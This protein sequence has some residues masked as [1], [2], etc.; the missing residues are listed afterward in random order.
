MQNHLYRTLLIVGVVLASA[1]QVYPTVGWVLLDDEQR[2]ARTEKWNEEDLARLREDPGTLKKAGYRIKRWSEYDRGMVINLGL[3]LLGGLHMVLGFDMTPEALERELTESDV[4]D[5]ILRNVR[6]RVNE[7]EAKEPIIQKLGSN[8]IQIQLP[9]EKD[10]QRAKNLIMKTAFLTFHIVSGPDETIKILSALDAHFANGFVPFLDPPSGRGG[11]FEVRLEHFDLVNSLVQQALE[12]PGLIPPDTTIAFSPPPAPWQ[13]SGYLIYVM[14]KKEGMT[15]EDLKSAVARPDDQSPSS[16]LILFEFGA[17]GSR[18]FARLTEENV[19]RSMAIVVDGHVVSAPNISER[20]FGSGRITGSFSQEE[21]QDLA[22]ALNSGSMPVPVREDYTAIVGPTLG[23]DSVERGINSSVIGLVLVMVFMLLYYRVA[24]IVA[25]ISLA[26]NALLILGAFGY[27]DVTLTLPGI[28]G[29][30]L[31][32]GMA[33]D[34]NV[35]IFE[36]I[37][38]EQAT[39][40]SFAAC[41]E[42][43]FDSATSAII[44]ANVTT[45]IAAAVL[46]QFGT[47]PVQGFAIA[48]SIGVVSSVFSA[49]VITRALMDFIA[50]HKL[51]ERLGMA[52]LV[53]PGTKF[54]FLEKRRICAIVSVLAILA[55]AGIFA[56]RGADNFGVDFKNGT[57]AIVSL[58]SAVAV[59]AGSLRDALTDA[60]FDAPT[61][62]EYEETD[63]EHPN[64]F[65]IRVGETGQEEGASN[66]PVSTRIQ[67]AL[68]PLTDNPTSTD[69]DAEVTILRAETVGPAVG[70][71][72]QRDALNAIFFALIFIVLYLWF[73]FEWKFALGAV[74]ALTHDVLIVIGIIALAG[75]EITIPVIAAL[76]TIIGYSLN[77]TIVVF[78]RIREDIG[79]NKARGLS[80]MENL[81]MSINRTLSRTLLTSITTLFVVVVLFIFGGSAINDFAFALIAGVIVGTYSSVFVATPVVYAWENWRGSGLGGHGP[82]SPSDEG[83]GRTGGTRRRRR[84][85]TSTA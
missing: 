70:E 82:A 84:Q 51:V 47:G 62:Q 71:R 20:I 60:G 25:N 40:K 76:L 78:D 36:R 26:I 85:K 11:E 15:G 67:Q 14:K 1:F 50:D 79:L 39:G 31:T 22:I 46:T 66:T 41:V 33:V 28:A 19:N 54:K 6:N 58:H 45:L 68:L 72:L 17:D 13:D 21:A 8:Q 34:A 3:D 38:E 2:A 49:L 65:N 9:G 42:G 32:I 56:A 24:G 4:Q 53:P 55:G 43:G 12:V 18:D 59:S 35:L 75:R 69:L 63:A 77:D 27:F 61:V 37:R 81:N 5:I 30:I 80:L 83:R 74:V 73:R 16:W 48:L 7:Y 64:S 10:I 57:N 44:D 23:R 29:L 52:S